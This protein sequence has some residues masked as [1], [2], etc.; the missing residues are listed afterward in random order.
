MWI[1]C[2]EYEVRTVQETQ[3]SSRVNYR[4]ATQ[5]AVQSGMGAHRC[6]V[7]RPGRFNGLAKL[8]GDLDFQV[9]ATLNAVVSNTNDGGHPNI[10]RCKDIVADFEGLWA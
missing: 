1:E 8:D 9:V 3:Q 4:C 10:A 7:G 2:S 6:G 5:K